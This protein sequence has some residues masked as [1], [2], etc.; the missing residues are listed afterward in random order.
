MWCGCVVTDAVFPNSP[1][2][3][4]SSRYTMA[5]LAVG[6]KAEEPAFYTS[7]TEVGAPALPMP[8]TLPHVGLPRQE[9]L[10][11]TVTAESPAANADSMMEEVDNNDG[12]LQ[13]CLELLNAKH[14]EFGSTASG[15][16]T[17]KKRLQRVSTAGQWE[18]FLHTIGNAIP[19]RHHHRTA[20][21]VQPTS[22]ARRRPGVSRGSKRHPAGR[23]PK[24]DPVR[25]RTKR[26]RNLQHNVTRNQPN[27]KPHG[28]GH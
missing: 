21:H 11:N 6:E 10:P 16:Q 22:S 4:C 28:D 7:L 23:P 19:M 25:H 1:P 5:V 15:L 2:V 18:S 27:A 8:I 14:H 17:L 12:L 3:D 20:I 26:R 9:E 24:S 13:T